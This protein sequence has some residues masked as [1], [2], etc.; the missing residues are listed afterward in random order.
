MGP[1]A[2]A[3]MRREQERKASGEADAPMSQDQEE[4]MQ[5]IVS[6][7]EMAEILMDPAMQIIM[8]EC[9]VPGR[10]HAYMQHPQYG[11]KLRKLMEAGLLKVG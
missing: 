7:P 1:L 9:A 5:R 3:A 4:M 6:D 11:P 2:E 10:M 8:Q